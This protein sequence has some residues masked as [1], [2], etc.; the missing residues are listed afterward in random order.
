ML[1]LP[2]E[3]TLA[4]LNLFS[5]ELLFVG[6]ILFKLIGKYDEEIF[7]RLVPVSI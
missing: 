5:C 7:N 3:L 6:F 4:D 2:L 1:T